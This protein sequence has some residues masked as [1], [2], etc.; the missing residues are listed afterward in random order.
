MDSPRHRVQMQLLIDSLEDAWQQRQDFYVGGNMFVYFSELQ[1]KGHDFRGPDVFVVLD[2][3]RKDR[4]AWVAWEEGGR[5]PDVVI[6]LTSES[7]AQVDRGEKKRVYA[8]VWRLPEYF[9]FDPHTAE[10]EAYR[11]DSET[12]DYVRVEADADGDYPVRVLGL[13]LGVRPGRFHLH[14]GLF[15]RW[16]DA[17]GTV[18]P[19][20]KERADTEKQRADEAE[21]RLGRLLKQ[22]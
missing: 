5:L 10:L 14:D 8:K 18:L 11:L 7:T 19:T 3:E 12:R 21:A 22:D 6:E 9:I 2:T 16:L 1:V 15:L 17:H 20:Q 13:R 4:R